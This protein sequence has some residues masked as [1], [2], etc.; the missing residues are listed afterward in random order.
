MRQ[1]IPQMIANCRALIDALPAARPPRPVTK[2]AAPTSATPVWDDMRCLAES[3]LQTGQVDTLMQGL[4]R[5]ALEQPALY[6]RYIEERRHPQGVD[7]A[8]GASPD[9]PLTVQVTHPQGV[10]KD[11]DG[12]PLAWEQQV[13]HW[14]DNPGTYERYRRH[15]ATAPRRPRG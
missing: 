4:E 3:Y 11:R 5:V 2:Q 10:K 14:R 1:S 7:K 6:Q 12:V 9:S 8:R 13:Q 15:F